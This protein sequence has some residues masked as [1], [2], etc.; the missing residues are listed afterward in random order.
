VNLKGEVFRALSE[1]V[2]AEWAGRHDFH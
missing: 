1:K 2:G